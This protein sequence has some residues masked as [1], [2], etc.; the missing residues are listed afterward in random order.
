MRALA[1]RAFW[2]IVVACCFATPSIA[3]DCGAAA[4]VR[5]GR[6]M[7]TGDTFVTFSVR[8]KPCAEGCSGHVEY[9]IHYIDKNGNKHFD[10]SLVEWRS[11]QGEPVEISDEGYEG[12]CSK[13]SFS[14]CKAMGTQILRVSCHH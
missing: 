10:G 8:A 12:H 13:S 14:P 3:A 4:T 7:D 11:E 1:W 9:R 2:G 6:I 5:E